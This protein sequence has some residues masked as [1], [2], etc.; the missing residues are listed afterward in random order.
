M[1]QLTAVRLYMDIA[2]VK[3]KLQVRKGVLAT[4]YDQLILITA[5]LW[6]AL[7]LN[8]TRGRPIICLL[9]CIIT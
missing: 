4:C 3:A 8:A 7:N 6:L 1:Q 5:D 2:R 9:L